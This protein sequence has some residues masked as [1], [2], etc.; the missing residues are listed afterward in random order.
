MGV[1]PPTRMQSCESILAI[2]F[3]TA[4]YQPES[5]CSL[6][7]TL[8]R[9][10][11]IV[12]RESARIRPYTGKD[13]CF[14]ELHGIRWRDVKDEP[15]FDTVWER[16]RPLWEQADLV[17]AHNV[18]FDLRVLF[19][20]ARRANLVPEPRWHACT[21][22][23][24][25]NRWPDL[26]NHKLNTVCSKLNIRLTHHDALSDASACAGVYLAAMKLSPRVT[27]QATD[28]WTPTSVPVSTW[29]TISDHIGRKPRRQSTPVA[30]PAAGK[31]RAV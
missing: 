28:A 23:L 27:V 10:T 8:V 13:F 20:C 25:R 29:K 30:R 5:A 7:A 31:Q 21:V 24:S 4:N 3:E 12:A 11:E 15:C 17:I 2:D 6:G 19:A 14:T 26:P 18:S 16:F 9:G 1:Q 22:A